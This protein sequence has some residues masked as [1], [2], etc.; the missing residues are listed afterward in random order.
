MQ[1]MINGHS[2][3][4]PPARVRAQCFVDLVSRF[5]RPFRFRVEVW[6]VD[7][8]D[9]RIYEIVALNDSDA[10]RAGLT[11]FEHEMMLRATH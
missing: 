6:G 1:P 4:T 5:Q 3:L 7:I 8:P 11:R 2:V 9:R 10:A